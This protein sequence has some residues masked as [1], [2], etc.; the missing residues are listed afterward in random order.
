MTLSISQDPSSLALQ[1]INS[2]HLPAQTPTYPV[3]SIDY[4][5]WTLLHHSSWYHSHQ[6]QQHI[7]VNTPDKHISETDN[8]KPAQSENKE[9]KQ[10]KEQNIHQQTQ[11][12]TSVLRPIV[13]TKVGV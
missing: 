2:R 6:N 12:Q 4:F 5:L 9:R 8:K 7:T 3:D 11:I 13:T 10:T 1:Q